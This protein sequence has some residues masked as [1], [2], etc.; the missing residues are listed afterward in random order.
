MHSSV[1]RVTQHTR[2]ASGL[3]I[4]NH[5]C[6]TLGLEIFFTCKVLKHGSLFCLSSPKIAGNLYA[7]RPNMK[8]ISCFAERAEVVAISWCPTRGVP[9]ASTPAMA[10]RIRTNIHALES[11]FEPVAG[12]LG[13]QIFVEED[14]K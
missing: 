7:S 2:R 8:N 6:A 11:T 10:S 12:C 1:P 3:S 5:A 4:G 14:G 9:E 13:V